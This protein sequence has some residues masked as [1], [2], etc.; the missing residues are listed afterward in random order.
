LQKQEV[1]VAEEN[2]EFALVVNGLS[3]DEVVVS[4]FSS[5]LQDGEK[6]EVI[7]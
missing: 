1:I 5:D 3:K 7:K 2:E 4:H 6:V